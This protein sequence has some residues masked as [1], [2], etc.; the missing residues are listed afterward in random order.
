MHFKKHITTILLL[1]VSSFAMAQVKFEARVSKNKLGVN[2]RLRISFEMNQDGDNFNPPS[3]S[4]FTVVGGPNQSVS[5]SWVNGKRTYKKTYTYFLA[6]KKRGNFTISQAT[7]NIDGQTYKTVPIK[8]QVTAAVDIPKD[9]NDPNY[10]ASQGIH[11]VAE[12]S[13]NNPYLNEAITVVYK[14]YVSPTVNLYNTG[15]FDIP[16]FNDFWK[17][18][19]HI[20]E[21]KYQNGSYNGENYNYLVY[22]KIV[23]YPQK[24]GELE[25]DPASLNVS[26]AVPSNRRDIFG[27]MLMTR[28]NKIISTRKKTIQVK[29]LPETGKP[30]DFTGAVGNFSLHVS[31]SKKALDANESIQLKVN[32]KGNGNLK[33]FK[34]PKISLPS[35]LEV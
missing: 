2:E 3:F 26:L 10:L 25:I 6:P 13:K 9:P 35:S 5:N 20:K 11:L 28:V 30:I 21:S 33:L 31:S 4:G 15:V 8:I 17:Q 18:Q 23:L 1:L 19:I 29:A 12:V 27:S 16:K 14:I 22:K 32:V 7:I 34:L 24:T